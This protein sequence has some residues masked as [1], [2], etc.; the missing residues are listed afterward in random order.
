MV[1]ST[2][3]EELKDYNIE[4]QPNKT[5]CFLIDKNRI[6]SKTDGIEAVKQAIYLIL[7]TERYRYA[8]YSWNYGVE[9]EY[10][11]GKDVNYVIAKLPA[12]ITEA[13]LQDE[14]I[15]DVKDFKFTRG[16]YQLSVNFTAVTIVGN[17]EINK[18]VNLN[19]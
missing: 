4:K 6:I 12:R 9:L 19:V 7:N 14:R 3:L 5:Y 18:V 17:I 16:R 10:L 1:P 11:F 15:A 2:S 13:L 8:I